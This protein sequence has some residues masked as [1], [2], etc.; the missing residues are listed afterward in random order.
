MLELE[1]NVPNVGGLMY[2]VL[3]WD[4]R[5]AV[6][7][8]AGLPG[9]GDRILELV[10]KEGVQPERLTKIIITHHDMD[11]IG[12]LA[13]ITALAGSRQQELKVEVLSHEIEKPYIQGELMPIKFTPEMLEQLKKQLAELPQEHQKEFQAMFAANKP[14]VTGT[15]SH[16]LELQCCGGMT[17]IHTPGHTPGHICI[18]LKKFKTLI[19][20][21]ALNA[22]SGELMGPNPQ[23]TYDMAK[24]KQSLTALAD[25]DI[26][27][28]LCYH[29]GVVA[30]DLNSKIKELSF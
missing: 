25:F 22:D 29:G 14:K 4:D 15:V 6:L 5:E 27:R 21:D 8:D 19:A 16:K 24:A 10:S 1:P 17:V 12:S 23:H 3:V 7:V 20:G 11:H 26:Q 30:G 18:Y 13:Q 9:Q 28:I 2:P